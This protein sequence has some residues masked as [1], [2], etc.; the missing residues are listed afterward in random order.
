VLPGSS[1]KTSTD[2]GQNKPK[3]SPITKHQKKPNVAG[4]TQGWQHCGRLIL[5][6]TLP[7]QTLAPQTSAPLP[8]PDTCLVLYTHHGGEG[9]GGNVRGRRI[10][11]GSQSITLH[12]HRSLDGHSFLWIDWCKKQLRCDQVSVA[13]CSG[14]GAGNQSFCNLIAIIKDAIIDINI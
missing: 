8:P 11:G 14:S 2:C 6:M 10:S 4:K 1:K 7:F 3:S 5:D 9:G 13:F 12:R